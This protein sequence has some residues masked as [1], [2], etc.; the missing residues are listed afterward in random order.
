MVINIQYHDFNKGCRFHGTNKS[1]ISLNHKEVKVIC[2][3]I[4]ATSCIDLPGVWINVKECSGPRYQCVLDHRAWVLV[5]CMNKQIQTGAYWYLLCDISNKGRHCED[6]IIVI[7]VLHGH[8]KCGRVVQNWTNSIGCKY[9]KIVRLDC[10][11]VEGLDY[12]N[13]SSM[14]INSKVSPVSHHGESDYSIA[15][16]ISISNINF[17]DNFTHFNILRHSDC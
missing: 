16:N 2:L 13:H 14:D 1:V 5:F 15:V 9:C 3:P 8:C 11:S 7:P 17:L 12:R 4:Y 10:F 6:R